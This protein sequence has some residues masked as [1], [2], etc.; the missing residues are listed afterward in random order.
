MLNFY[1]NRMG[2]KLSGERRKVLQRAKSEL[3]ALYG[4]EQLTSH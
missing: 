3:R 2:T 4:K 1:I